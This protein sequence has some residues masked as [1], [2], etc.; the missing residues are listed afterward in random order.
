[1]VCIFPVIKHVNEDCFRNVTTYS[2]LQFSS[3]KKPRMI[4]FVHTL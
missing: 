3:M 2:T 1:M 4:N